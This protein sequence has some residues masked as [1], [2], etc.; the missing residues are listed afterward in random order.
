M[1]GNQ[2]EKENTEKK[3]VRDYK[4]EKLKLTPEEKEAI[5]T[6]IAERLKDVV[7]M[8]ARQRAEEVLNYLLACCEASDE[9]INPNDPIEIIFRVEFLWNDI[10]QVL[11]RLGRKKE[12][13]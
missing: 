11:G 1:H 2:K 7:Y 10:L 9:P 5:I 13:R 12:K 8:K 6:E 4:M 3:G